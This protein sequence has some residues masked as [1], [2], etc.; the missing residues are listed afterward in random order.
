MLWNCRD[1]GSLRHDLVVVIDAGSLEAPLPMGV[2][3]IVNVAD[4]PVFFFEH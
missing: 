2:V 1:L 4:L 3:V